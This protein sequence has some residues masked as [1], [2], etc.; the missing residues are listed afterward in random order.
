MAELGRVT[1]QTAL[2]RLRSA[3]PPLLIVLIPISAVLAVQA[4][5]VV[6]ILFKRGEFDTAS[7]E[8]T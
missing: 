7:V 3:L 8:I 2:D 1:R 5:S 4:E 6:E